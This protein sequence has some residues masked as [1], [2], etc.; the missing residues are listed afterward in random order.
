MDFTDGGD[1]VDDEIDA[2][3]HRKYGRYPGPV[4]SITSPLARSTTLKII[5]H[6][7]D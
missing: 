3:Y 1:D 4:Q 5:P 2:A 7:P 6:Q